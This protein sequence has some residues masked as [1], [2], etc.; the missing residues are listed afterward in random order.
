MR[1]CVVFLILGALT[2]CSTTPPEL[3]DCEIP[4]APESAQQP[5]ILPDLPAVVSST[6]TTATFDL[7]G[8][9]RLKQYRIAS[10][11]NM[12]IASDNAGALEAR[13]ESV[14]YLIE[15]GKSAKAFAAVRQEQLDIERR[16]HFIDNWFYRGLIALG[17]I[18]VVAQ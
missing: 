6:E 11:T 8:M 4:L 14:N 5:I 7:E 17:I 10:E 2:A 1:I 9:K 3:P 16:D 12:T 13:N 18:A 15:C